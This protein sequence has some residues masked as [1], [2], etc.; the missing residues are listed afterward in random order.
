MRP[1]VSEDGKSISYVCFMRAVVDTD[2]ID[3]QRAMETKKASEQNAKYQN[4]IQALQAENERLRKKYIQT[5]QEST[6]AE[7]LRQIQQNTSALNQAYKN[8]V[9]LETYIDDLNAASS[10]ALQVGDFYLGMPLDE[11]QRLIPDKMAKAGWSARYNLSGAD[12]T[13]VISGNDGQSIEERFSYT[14]FKDDGVRDFFVMFS[15]NSKVAAELMYKIAATNFAIITGVPYSSGNS[16]ENPHSIWDVND[17]AAH[18]QI[19]LGESKSGLYKYHVSIMRSINTAG[20]WNLKHHPMDM[21]YVTKFLRMCVG[22]W[23]DQNGNRV[24]S[25]TENTING[26]NVLAGYDFAG[27]GIN[28]SGYFRILE[29][30]GYRDIKLSPRGE[31]LLEIDEKLTL[32]KGIIPFYNESVNGIYLGMSK[33]ELLQLH[34]QPDT[35]EN[36]RGTD[37]WTYDDM[38]IEL[39]FSHDFIFNMDLMNGGNWHFD[40]TGL[41]YYNTPEEYADAYDFR[42]YRGERSI[43]R[44]GEYS[45][46]YAI[47][48]GSYLFFWKY[49]QCLQVS[50]YNN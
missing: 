3:L 8:S 23:Y 1:V 24:L 11:I 34:G 20:K 46:A 32:R 25:I 22:D 15:T 18:I 40:K 48:D 27:G 36:H 6:R 5:Q 21:K 43:P 17:G 30:S 2:K 49:P 31:K 50:V 45:G 41:N 35:Q 44:T 33:K 38:G 13:R 26:C 42:N 16:L 47:G 9:G 7:L 28:S 10:S 39:S 19:G 4:D 37:V 29:K 12:Y 14:A